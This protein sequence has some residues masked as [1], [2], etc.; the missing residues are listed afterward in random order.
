MFACVYLR[1]MQVKIIKELI[2]LIYKL[3]EFF[4]VAVFDNAFHYFL[5][6]LG[7][8]MVVSGKLIN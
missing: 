2:V 4:G 3:S 1:L 7:Q 6:C 8:L 5:I